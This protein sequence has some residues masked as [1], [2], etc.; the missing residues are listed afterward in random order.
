MVMGESSISK[1]KVQKHRGKMQYTLW[2]SQEPVGRKTYSHS[3]SA[4]FHAVLKLAMKICK[5]RHEKFAQ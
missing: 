5:K 3:Q 4:Y 2:L 1:G